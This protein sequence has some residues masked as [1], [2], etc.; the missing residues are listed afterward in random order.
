MTTSPASAIDATNDSVPSATAAISNAGA[1]VGNTAGEMADEVRG[2]IPAV[3]KLLS[4][5]VYH[6]CYFTTYGI[7]FPTVLLVN[8]IPGGISLAAGISDGARSARDY[9]RG[10]R[11]KASEKQQLLE[12]SVDEALTAITVATPETQMKTAGFTPITVE[13]EAE[14]VQNPARKKAAK[15]AARSVKPTRKRKKPGR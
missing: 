8:V 4:R 14:R 6:G 1:A 2:F 10:M 11:Q 5:A 7:T 13:A 9:V 15:P 12:A 3:G